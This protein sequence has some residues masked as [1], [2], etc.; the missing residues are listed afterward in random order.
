LSQVLSI[1]RHATTLSS[2]ADCVVLEF[3]GGGGQGEVYRARLNDKDVALKWYLPNCATPRQRASL[4]FLIRK[5]PPADRF[6][7]PL[8]LA[9]AANVPDFGYVMPLRDP[10][11]KGIAGLMKR[12]IDVSFRALTV[13]G[14][15]LAHSFLHLHSKGLCY[16]DISFGNV[17]LDPATGSILIC[18]NDNVAVDGDT[19]G[20]ILG[21]PRF[22][23]PEVV[24]GDSLPSIQTDLFSLAVLLFYLFMVHH[25]LE[26]ARELAIHSFDL[27]AMTRLYGADPRFVFDPRDES[28]RPV[29]GYHDNVLAFWPLYPQFLR[30]LFIRAF[31]AGLRDAEHGRVREG[32][33]RAA[34]V[35]LRDSILY[36]GGCGAENFYD[37]DALRSAGDPGKCWTCRAPLQLPYRLRVGRS[38]VMLNHDTAIFPHHIDERS[39]NDFSQPVAVV[40]RHPQ[41]LSIWGLKNVSRDRWSFSKSLDPRPMEL[42][43]GQSVTLE[44]GL[45]INFG[46]LEGEVRL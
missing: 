19:A 46:R 1:G 23:A 38:T 30:D 16:R 8:E 10:R 41:N 14:F 45:H 3:L 43:P 26:G 12:S 17:F 15:E 22:M 25:P 27:A 2:R 11:F 31:T 29:A 9:T 36:C 6:L 39:A 34:M 4:E 7:W 40:T 13:A 28:N 24:R 37:A 42:L 5:G 20:G 32:E 44:P 21:T 18:D 33:W 35:R